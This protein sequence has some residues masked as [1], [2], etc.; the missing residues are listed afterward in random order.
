M[1]F[2]SLCCHVAHFLPQPTA[3]VYVE[4]LI[5]LATQA[6]AT[7]RCTENVRNG[8]TR[9]YFYC[10]RALALSL[11]HACFP[12]LLYGVLCF[13]PPALGLLTLIELV[14]L[15]IFCS[16]DNMVLEPL[17]SAVCTTAVLKW[18]FCRPKQS[19]VNSRPAKIR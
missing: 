4:G 8:W 9:H 13:S 7:K 2:N 12:H 18:N 10:G 17:F 11:S 15:Q 19:R 6:P 16:Y 14:V 1:A 5:L 3:L